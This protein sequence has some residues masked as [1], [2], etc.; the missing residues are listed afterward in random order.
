MVNGGGSGALFTVGAYSTLA[1]SFTFAWGLAMFV[2]RPDIA[3]FLDEPRLVVTSD[4]NA[5]L[6]R[7][8]FYRRASQVCTVGGL[9]VLAA[10]IA[11][12]RVPVVVEGSILSG[13]G[14][15]AAGVTH[16]GVELARVKL[17]RVTRRTERRA[18]RTAGRG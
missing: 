15:A 10:G 2:L 11:A 14:L 7:W 12:S 1:G 9:V 5:R 8:T 17:A 18:R 6:F 16:V 13:L 4:A 3:V